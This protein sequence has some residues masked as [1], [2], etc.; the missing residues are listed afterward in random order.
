MRFAG[1]L[2]LLV[3]CGKGEEATVPSETAGAD[4]R[5]KLLNPHLASE[6]APEKFR[7]KLPEVSAAMADRKLEFTPDGLEVIAETA[8]E[9][10][11][12]VRA[13]RAILENLLLD[14]LYELP[15]RK[16]TEEFV[17]DAKVA[18]GEVSL[19]RGLTAADLDPEDDTEASAESSDDEQVT[20]PERESA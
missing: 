13:L 7:A 2:I 19:A 8:I 10:E 15:C 20:P 11:T 14:L 5:S 1:I 6:T 12:G 17:V 18:R 3:A 9:R 4:A 16:D